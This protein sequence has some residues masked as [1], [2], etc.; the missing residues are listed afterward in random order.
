MS[1]C[2]NL[3][4]SLRQVQERILK[5]AECYVDHDDCLKTGTMAPQYQINDPAS[6]LQCFCLAI[7]GYDAFL[8]SYFD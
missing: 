2:G 7:L 8:Q 6:K 4:I 3:Y 5:S 1:M